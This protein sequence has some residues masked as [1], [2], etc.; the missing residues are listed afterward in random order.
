QFVVEFQNILKKYHQ[1]SVFYAHIGDGELHLRPILDLKID[2]D[3]EMFH[4]ITDEVATLV[5]KFRGSLSGEHGDGRVRGE[6]IRKMIGEKNYQ[7]I[8]DLKK[9][10][11]P[12]DI[13]NPNKIVHTPKM[14]ESLRYEKNQKTNEFETVFDFGATGG[15]LR[16]AEKCNG[17]G[18]CRKSAIIGGTMCPSYMATKSEK[19]TTRARANILREFLT[20]STKPNKFDHQEI[21]EVY[22]LCLSCKGCK[23]ECPSNVDVAMMKAEF[24]HQYYK[25]N[26]VPF[27]TRMI[28]NFELNMKLA[29]VAPGIYNFLMSNSLTSSLAK[30]IMGIA[31]KRN[32]PLVYKTTLRKWAEHNL[33][34]LQPKNGSEKGSVH[35]FCD[36]YTNF[37]DTEVGIKAIKL[38]TKLGYRVTLP[39]H[40][41][42]G[43]TFLS[44]GLLEEAKKVAKTN[45]RML[46]GIVTAQEPL[47]GIEPSAILSF[48]DEYPL[49]VDKS[50]KQDANALA[51][52]CFL[53][54][55]FIAREAER[56]DKNL[57]TKETKTVKLHGHCH[58]KALSS[59]EFSKKI[60][61]FPVNYQV[62]IIPSGCCGMAGSFG[63]EKEHYDVSMN[64]GEL[65]LFPAIR[66][67]SADAIIAAPGTSC[68]HQIHD[69]TQREAKH[70][71]EVLYEALV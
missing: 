56:I 38:L 28:G 33:S 4:T 69:G 3:R 63:Y 42:S 30:N 61:S 6:F 47:L 48:R 65:V 53:I 41:E 12:N 37:N 21:K 18:D 34:A 66:N 25:S 45:V 10:W 68:R 52:N 35:L 29:S 58:Q 71:L 24:L 62:E 36:E 9:M 59:V 39:E 50:E 13:F 44:K 67:A 40:I 2:K 27:R 26:G 1:T 14:N 16:M 8:C 57:F 55:E 51:K 23:S 70:T 20:R 11:D 64:V 43:R 49:L 46:K 54:D 19:E 7:L 15:I 31:P 22:D 17:S 60:L 5:K 32:F